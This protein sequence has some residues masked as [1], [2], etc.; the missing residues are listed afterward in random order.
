MGGGRVL[1]GVVSL[2]LPIGSAKTVQEGKVC[3][4]SA[5]VD[6][7]D[8]VARNVKLR[9]CAKL[10]GRIVLTSKDRNRLVPTENIPKQR[11][12]G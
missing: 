6:S 5:W 9:I 11:R 8:H 3:C 10:S 7:F 2:G 1:V 4:I 12:I